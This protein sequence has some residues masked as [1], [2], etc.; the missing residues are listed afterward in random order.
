MKRGSRASPVM[1]IACPACGALPD[2]RRAS[3]RYPLGA[4]EN[5]CQRVLPR[6]GAASASAR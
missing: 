5:I 4:A 1:T 3:G 6:A 2:Q